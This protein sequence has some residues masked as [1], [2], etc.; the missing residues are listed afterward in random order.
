MVSTT[1]NTVGIFQIGTDRLTARLNKSGYQ[2]VFDITSESLSEFEENNPEIPSSDAKEIY[3]LAIQRTENLRMLFK[4]WQLHNDPVVKNIPKLSSNTGM[5]GMRSALKR[6]LGGGADFEDLFPERSPEGYAESASIQSLFSP[7]R[8]LTVLYKIARQ[9]HNPENKL[10]I[11]N[12]RPDLQSLILSQDN[13]NTEVSSLDILLDV[14][15][16]NVSSTLESLKDTYYPMTL[17]YDD[18]LMQIN[19]AVE[20]HATNLIGV[21]DTLLDT[22]RSCILQDTDA[23]S[24]IS[25]KCRISSPKISKSSGLIVGE[26]FYLEAKGKRLYFAN[27]M[28]TDSSISVHITLGKPQAAAVVLAKFKLIYDIKSGGYY[29]RVADGVLIDEIPLQS[30]FL[31]NDNGEHTGTKGPYC[32]MRDPGYHL[33]V[34]IEKLTDTSIRIFVP[35]NGYLGLGETVASHWENPLALNLNLNEALTFT[36]KKNETGDETIS[37]SEVIPPVADTTPSPTTRE[38]LSLTP[39]SFQLLVN[40]NTTVEDIANHY[41]VK[42][43]K[44]LDSIDLATALN[45]VDNFCRKTSL[46]FNE[47]LELTMQKDYQIK[48]NEYNSRFLKFGSTENVPVSTFGAVFLMGTEQIPLWVKQYNNVGNATNTPVLNFKADNV[49]ALAGR[50]EK[51]VRLAKSTGLSFEQLDW[52]ITNASK[53]VFEH[54]REIILDRKV[55]NAIAEFK[56][57]NKSYGITSDM[58]TA[59]IGEINTYAEEGKKSFYQATFSNVDGTTIPLGVSLQFAI[60]KQGL[61]E[62]ICCGAMGVTA[63]EFSRIGAYCFGDITQQIKVDETSIAQLYRLGKIPQMLGLSFEEAELLWKTMAGG[64]AT[65]LRTIGANSQSLQILDIIH[66]TEVLL[67]WMDAHQLDVVSLRAM[68][69][70]QYSG[71]A[72]PELY[73]FLAKVYQSTNSVARVSG[74]NDQNNLPVEKIYRA[75]A[76]AFNLKA[77][78]MAQIVNWVDKTNPEFTSKDF[79]HKLQYYFSKSYED[80]LTALEEQVD[81]L[82]W[83]QQLSQY[84]LIARWCGL[85]EQELTVMIEHPEQLLDGYNATPIPS[86]HLLLVLSRLKEWEQRVQVSSDEALRYFAQVNT[87]S[88][89]TDDAVKLLAHIHGWNEG[90][91]TSMNNYL[92][93]DDAYPKNF[94]QVFTLESWVNLGKQL[95]VGSRTLGELVELIEENETAES[96][97]LITSVARS[98]MASVQSEFNLTKTGGKEYV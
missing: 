38:T 7:G 55:L 42:A 62:S 12:R 83:C 79:W 33:P 26:E 5:Q 48:S 46:S 11:D 27:V 64:E 96:T 95:N 13:M 22:Q 98:L 30:C 82:K 92:F 91:T 69:T 20:S 68:V 44:N 40:P 56:K 1:E 50:A 25:K 89:K 19:A 97:N 28:K 74:V 54:G 47:L 31:T 43:T 35:R 15:Q 60:D 57:L 87:K 75:L 73:N 76:T 63:D 17:P 94:E 2:T 53:A 51:L 16:P 77:N 29:L 93:G 4:A 71:T 10:H 6:S 24:R 90:D 86:L 37:V 8:Y 36:L 34:Q 59:F 84:V 23:I 85:N 58:F 65:L 9:L 18:N 21:W 39:N 32:L 88:I 70:N 41:N 80:E 78:V 52:L 3:K 14:L 66:C 61:Y 72:T 49:V 81:L 67:Q 45:D